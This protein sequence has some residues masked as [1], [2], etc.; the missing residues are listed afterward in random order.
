MIPH[1][2]EEQASILIVDDDRNMRTLL[3]HALEKDGY[4]VSTA[5]NGVQGLRVYKEV[6]PDI[7]LMDAAMP[8]MDGFQA[9]AALRRLPEGDETPVLMITGLNDEH[10]VD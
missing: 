10:S 9:C 6:L 7:V 5:V 8:E 4:E 3:Q 2:P 1:K